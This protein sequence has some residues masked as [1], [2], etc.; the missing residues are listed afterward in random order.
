[1]FITFTSHKFKPNPFYRAQLKELNILL[2]S[3]TLYPSI[4]NSRPTL[5]ITNTMTHENFSP[6]QTKIVHS[7]PFLFLL[8]NHSIFSRWTLC[9]LIAAP[10]FILHLLTNISFKHHILIFMASL[11]NYISSPLLKGRLRMLV[12]FCLSNNPFYKQSAFHKQEF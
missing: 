3:L 7:S 12:A 5:K 8:L 2:V 9:P 1:M 4:P 10:I 11:F 6:Y